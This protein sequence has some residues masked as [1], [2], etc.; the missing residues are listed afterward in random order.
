[1]SISYIFKD[2][3]SEALLRDS[4]REELAIL[5][6]L[7]ARGAQEPDAIAEVMQMRPSRIADALDYLIKKGL[8]QKAQDGICEEFSPCAAEDIFE[9]R[10]GAEIAATIRDHTLAGL[11]E[12]CAALLKKPV[13]ERWEIEDIT[14]LYEQ[15]GLGEEFIVSLFA[16]MRSRSACSVKALVNRAI[17]L[18][19]QGIDSHEALML[20]FKQREEKGEFERTVRR[21]FGIAGKLSDAE[22]AL[23]SRWTE[24]YGFGEQML[25]KAYDITTMQLSGKRSYEYMDTVLTRWYKAG[26]HSPEQVDAQNESFK[27]QRGA[28]D[29]AVSER[30]KYSRR[31]ETTPYGTFDTMDAF[32]RA[33]ERSYGSENEENKK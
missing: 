13:L 31:K 12:E 25:K 17:G 33:L 1:M 4:A 29:A 23:F 28:Q 7:Y 14:A 19:K 15:Y 11:L 8:V 5:I 16:D 9:A 30:K 18:H 24:E 10:G 22:R 20:F 26:I 21:V 27:E 3:P 2:W 6:L 32:Q